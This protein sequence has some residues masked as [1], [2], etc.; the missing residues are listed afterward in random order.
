M[1]PFERKA[2]AMARQNVLENACGAKAI[3]FM[4]LFDLFHLVVV[5]EVVTS[6]SGPTAP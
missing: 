3:H 1:R 4:S 2:Q 6:S 5:I